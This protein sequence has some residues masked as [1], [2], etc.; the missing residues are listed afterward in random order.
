M[1]SLFA[2]VL[3]A[4]PVAAAQ[5]DASDLVVV[6]SSAAG[7]PWDATDGTAGAAVLTHGHIGC[8][9]VDASGTC[10][11][12]VWGRV[13]GAQWIW[14]SQMSDPA[15]PQA[16]F[17]K[18]F[19]VADNQAAQP[20]ALNIAADNL[21][22]VVL[23]GTEVA[24]GSTFTQG[25]N[26]AVDLRPG[27][28][29]IEISVTNIENGQTAYNN[30]A[31]LAWALRAVGPR[32][33]P[34][35]TTP[36]QPPVADA[37]E[38]QSV[39]EGSVVSLDGSGSRASTKPS[40]QASEQH[41]A[42][43]GGTSL[44]A[45]LVGLD[46]DAAGLRVQGS[47]DVGQGPAV[48]NTSI[49][50][51][52]DISGSSGDGGGCGGDVNG[53]RRSNTILDCEITA[54][55]K[56]HESVAAA[57]SVDKVAVIRFDTGASAV[58]LDP[59]SATATL[60]SPTA[61]KDADGVLDVIEAL[62]TL[63]VAGGTNFVP[64]A[65]TACQLLATTGSPNLVA[66]FLSDGQQN[67]SV[68]SVVP[69]TPPVTFQ[70]F[71]VG[72]N[73]KCASGAPVGARLLDLATRSGGTCTDVPTVTTLPDILP[74][75]IG[76]KITKV[77]Y[78]V[79][80]GEPVDL[81]EQLALPKAGPA[82]LDLAFDLPAALGTG[83]HRVCLTVT[84]TDAGG[85]SSQTT[86]SD[87]V[88]VTG[89]VAYSWRVV[90]SDGPPVFLSSP[91]SAQPGFVAADDGR[92]VLELTVSDGTGA[93]AADLVEVAVT[94]AHPAAEL[95]HGDSFAGGVTQVNG[96]LTD[97]GWQDT[98]Q[99]EVDWGD[100][101]VDTVAVTTAGAGWGTFFG[102]HVYRTA[103]AYDVAV[104][105]RDDDGGTDLVSVDQVQ[106]QTPVAVWANSA[107]ASRSLDWAGG[108]GTIEGRV[109]TN[110][111]LRFVG[112]AK[113]V[114]GPATYAGSLS[115]DTTKNSFVPL[116]V[117][118]PV[119]DFPIRPQV[120]DFRPG[121]LVA[122]E[123]GPAY[124]DMSDQCA[125]GS[126]HDVQ[127]ALAPG[128]YY[129]DCDIMLNGSQ[130]G[131]R[132]TLVSEGRIKL[133]GS[134]PAFQPYRDGLLLLAGAAGDKAIDIST[135][136]SKFLGVLFAGSG[137]ISI[138][139]NT[140][141][142]FCGILGDTVE[143][144]G[145]D[146]SVRG[147]DCGRPGTTV[148][149]PV[150]VPDLTAGITVDRPAA[151][152]SDTLGYDLRVTNEGATLVVPSL[153][154]LENVDTAPAT[155]TG[156][157]FA[158]ERQD[159]AS[160]EWS[161]VTSLGEDRMSVH[162]RSNPSSGVTYP[163]DGAVSGTTVA[164]G[165]WATWGLQAVLDLDPALV[166][167]LLDPA[168]TSGVRTRV[169]FELSPT[170]I[171]ARRLYTFG[172]DFAP[173]LRE[174]AADVS[175]AEV[176]AIL[177]DG[178]ARVVTAA[179]EPALATLAPGATVTVRRSWDVPVPAAR[180]GSESDAGYLS[181]LVALDGTRLTGA[182]Y[183]LAA[184]GVGR[185][186]APLVHTGTTR[187]LPVVG[188]STTGAT[189]IPAGTSSDYALGLAN[190][191]SVTAS[192]LEITATADQAPLAVAGAPA[193]LAAGEL[194]EAHTTYAA[195]AASRG[196][197]VLRGTA[198]WTDARG[199]EYGVTGS[200]LAVDRQVP[201][202]L[203]ASLTDALHTDV[204]G[205]GVVSPGDTLRYTVT[206][207]NGGGLPL[208]GV[209][210]SVA[211]GSGSSLV[212]GSGRT[213]DGGT[214]ELT[215]GVASFTLPSI[216]AATSRTVTFDVR[217]DDPFEVS[218]GRLQTQGTVSA[219]GFEA[220]QTDDP[221]LPGPADP[222]R[223]TVTIP[224]PALTASLT[225]RLVVD[226]DGN[227]VV[228]A[229]D[230]LAYGG[231]VSSVGTQQVTGIRVVV[232]PPAG[233]TLVPGSVTASQGEAVAGTDV[234][235]AVGTLAPFQQ[236]SLGFR[237][238]LANPL[239]AGTTSIVVTG[240]VSSDQL[241]PIVTDDPQTVADGDP[242]SVP[243]G[244]PAGNPE[245]PGPTASSVSPAD[246]QR[247]A[248]PTTVTA[249][250]TAPANAVVTTWK[251][252]LEPAGG[253][254]ATVLATGNS[255]QPTASVEATVDPTLLA[256][257]LYVIRIISSSSDGG[258]G[259][260][261][262]SLLV[263]GE[264]KPGRMTT[265]FADH[266]VGLGGLPLQVVRSYDSFD[267][268]TGDF[269]VGW[270]VD[271]ADFRVATATPL[272]RS[273]WSARSETCGLVFCTLRY[274]STTPHFV[275]VVWP[276]GRQEAFD[277][278]GVNGSTFFPGLAE[279]RFQARTGSNTTSKLEVVGD[280]SLFFIGDSAYTGAFGTGGIFDPTTFK[281]TSSNGVSYVIDRQQGLRSMSDRSGN[282]LTFTDDGV[283]SSV[284][285]SITY[286]RDAVGR[287]TEIESPAGTTRYGYQAGDLVSSVD[288]AGV[289]TTYLYDGAHRLTEVRGPGG[290]SLGSAE[291]DAAGRMIAWTDAG[292]H[293]TEYSADIG[294]RQER[295]T[296][297]TG[298]LT[299]VSS[300]N[301][302]GDLTR[303]DQIFDGQTHTTR[304]TYDDRHRPTTET[305]PSG[306]VTR[307]DWTPTGD[308]RSITGPDG[309][310][311]RYEYDANGRL[312]REVAPGG[313]VL[314]ELTYDAA[315]NV[316][317][318]KRADGSVARFEY[319]SLGRLT[320]LRNGE[321]VVQ[322]F[323]YDA[324]HR[325]ASVTDATGAVKAYTYDAKGRVLTFDD[326]DNPETRFSYD[327]YGRLTSA[328]DA[329]GGTRRWEWNDHGQLVRET[330]LRGEVTEY[331][332]DASGRLATRTDRNGAVTTFG[333]DAA[334]R[335]VSEAST[336]N[337]VTFQY[338][339]LGRVVEATDDDS[340]VA[341][342]Y[343]RDSNVVRQSQRAANGSPLPAVTLEYGYSPTGDR[344]SLLGPDGQRS[345]E[346]DATGA[347][348]A[349]TDARGGRYQVGYAPNGAVNRIAMPNGAV[350]Q[351]GWSPQGS[352]ASRSTSVAGVPVFESSYEH[353]A[354]GLRTA[355]VDGSGRH[356]FDYDGSGRLT[357]AD[358]PAGSGLADET[359]A[360]D[361]MG[362]R[363]SQGAAFDM[364]YRL[365]GDDRY[366]YAYDDEGNLVRRTD[367]RTGSVR[368]LEW[369]VNGELLSVT[370]DGRTTRYRYD[371]FGR[372]IEVRG[373]DGRVLRYA[374]DGSNV[375]LVLDAA[376]AI[377]ESYTT[378]EVAGLFLSRTT[379]DGTTYPVF[380]G[381]GSV[382]GY[383]G[384][385]GQLT[386]ARAYS[387]FGESS[388]GR[389]TY[390]YT[391]HQFD[392]DT[393]LIYARARYYDPA[394]GRFLSEDPAPALNPYPYADNQPCSRTD[395]TGATSVEYAMK[396]RLGSQIARYLGEEAGTFICA[397]IL[398]T[399]LTM[400]GLPSRN[401]KGQA[402]EDLIRRIQGSD[403][404]RL[405]PY[406]GPVH[407]TTRYPDFIENGRLGE[408][409][410]VLRQAFTK[411][412]EDLIGEAD[413]RGNGPAI[414][415]V[416]HNTQLSGKLLEQAK[417][418]KLT[419]LQ[420]LPG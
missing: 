74:A 4:V 23:N 305:G 386:E 178:E 323:T 302:H 150:V 86:C 316:L 61:D 289:E 167:T 250:L 158:V 221:A 393:G 110:G 206:V 69:C 405:A 181:R 354:T 251:V 208:T 218:T 263:D 38:D 213:P 54:A 44:G 72:L 39:V 19:H 11:G 154:G 117:Q 41:G 207:R 228:S 415:V 387:A 148:S 278:V 5:A 97:E 388:G 111:E 257:G 377:V 244:D 224:H 119:Q 66:A 22:S 142:F 171:Q 372:R 65:R 147:A 271:V 103:G 268:S 376:G 16:A 375:A 240:T 98:H 56:L 173:R 417:N 358:R 201:A 330:D 137:E 407:G 384:A 374:Y 76:S 320:A 360:Y 410:N 128:V 129:A 321:T 12:G 93:T 107:T 192:A 230:T 418:G 151:L 314:S 18:T 335:L 28:N 24:S 113:T 202:S 59:T 71:A 190:L 373:S 104:T 411:Q 252:V 124:H 31:G 57:G 266:E 87:L 265:S 115:A 371:P 205:D 343:D 84:G 290:R 243:V 196:T 416:R 125:A 231:T 188:I 131:G 92:Y 351:L 212:A 326:G 256:N 331:S 90:S 259:T 132:V 109:H 203:G 161:P 180:G 296:D 254:E 217:V 34:P 130:I 214:V 116:P 193:E 49:A 210:G 204:A 105:V 281:L 357:S 239:P 48:Q 184:G 235:V 327:A 43:P 291:Y 282:S 245:L 324:A 45:S 322:R 295:Q 144:T 398:N 95:S 191:G 325:V 248:V 399:V 391:G 166:R 67:S 46:P 82:D 9:G 412:I 200:D 260:S 309:R 342:A 396:S 381:L 227:G 253:G 216:A 353:D 199:N 315:G 143:I 145:A 229:G 10:T 379:A 51:V 306:A 169:D 276:D 36:Y 255:G 78:T 238:R 337:T 20:A 332:Y 363:T 370:D 106:V 139:G 155:L 288:V 297:A 165:G 304:W 162:L 153:I 29:T 311:V 333:Y 77:A 146:V 88:T 352:I 58:D 262:T 15:K 347:L 404:G 382:V 118:A 233:T 355:M 198:A 294:S 420:C 287:I 91:T 156:Y 303:S 348:A 232:A 135:A 99:A 301:D 378:T 264:F 299:T 359:F 37:G 389:Q 317:S 108:S 345:Y 226:A 80:G 182:A 275:S 141:R 163:A 64:A 310:T 269:G 346:Y 127:V 152:P 361:V 383:T 236:M 26:F 2:S 7:D 318:E 62:R 160:G 6:A 298:R 40:L 14:R 328:V 112:A 100:G 1:L 134:R 122:R 365:T 223:T 183:V 149:S 261:S 164:P 55:M 136:T 120:A 401:A 319:D 121:G 390:G 362:N 312:F 168:V 272:G 102:S 367:R 283:T 350:D 270:H 280:D 402:A 293:R 157:S 397:T 349:V 138:A 279:A 408:I 70:A 197:L 194:A 308:V 277:L 140:N 79:D 126:W 96:T 341:F 52:I 285:P 35:P 68:T 368:T 63:R 25:T 286:T 75:V 336:T 300:Y 409:K 170:A 101:T 42:L 47:V 195:P 174:L 60:V 273:G 85:S 403:P 187:Q 344:T 13:E 364:G 32:D 73:S 366:T 175:D 33:N 356:T 3:M 385:T 27:S 94:N 8:T 313:A 215:D 267:A 209:A 414:L 237:L 329:A 234:D 186:V 114:R 258:T 419:I 220:I 242:S 395:P 334:G 81:S 21:F 17:T 394:L 292:G 176:T 249:T 225:G 400:A 185:L 30:P 159:P 392:A 189:A 50:Y 246:G 241:D 247:I 123:V 406:T 340:A 413:R 83:S 89:E 219:D 380:D 369:G 172:T 53:D 133:S 211:A 177:P 179:D 284:G 274:T 339:G 307:M 338:D 222:T